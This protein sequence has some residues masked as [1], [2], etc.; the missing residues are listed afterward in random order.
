VKWRG[1]GHDVSLGLAIGE[2]DMVGAGSILC[3]NGG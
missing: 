3:D 1:P 2:G